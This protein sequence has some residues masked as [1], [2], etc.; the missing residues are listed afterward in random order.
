MLK[1]IFNYP[2][3]LVKKVIFLSLPNW[4]DKLIGSF[5]PK[6]RMLTIRKKLRNRYS[7]II[8]WKSVQQAKS[9]IVVTIILCF[10]L[11]TIS[12]RTNFKTGFL[13]SEICPNSIELVQK[14]NHSWNRQR[15]DRP[16]ISSRKSLLIYPI[17][18]IGR[19][20]NLPN[21]KKVNQI[22]S[23]LNLRKNK[24][25][26]IDKNQLSEQ[27]K[28]NLQDFIN[29]V[30]NDLQPPGI[31]NRTLPEIYS[32]VEQLEAKLTLSNLVLDDQQEARLQKQKRSQKIV[33]KARK[34]KEK[35]K[36]RL[37]TLSNLRKEL[38]EK[39]PFLK[40]YCFPV[41]ELIV[42]IETE[43]EMNLLSSES[44]FDFLKRRIE[45]EI[46]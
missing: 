14:L 27:E 29:V 33:D 43:L 12:F 30:K 19:G 37:M 25:T 24:K 22:Q 38:Q 10:N 26:I 41:V 17:L 21:P 20:G 31:R 16:S 18:R 6:E 5:Y 11:S 42:D 45:T 8:L 40:D 7:S 23:M 1:N 9:T 32:Q 46:F 13:I 15:Y 3:T 34:R 36:R 2:R 39:N 28:N 4:N 44:E 35:E